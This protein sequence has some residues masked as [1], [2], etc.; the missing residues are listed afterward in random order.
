MSNQLER[1]FWGK[2]SCWPNGAPQ[3]CQTLPGSGSRIVD[4]IEP[5]DWRLGWLV[6][7]QPIRLCGW[8]YGGRV[9][10]MGGRLVGRSEVG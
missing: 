1:G 4:R 2:I 9:M 8:V 10:V 5:P 6:W 3:P 7:G